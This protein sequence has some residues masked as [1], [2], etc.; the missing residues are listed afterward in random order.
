MYVHTYVNSF[1][2]RTL[3]N[4]FYLTDLLVSK[5]VRLDKCT[6]KKHLGFILLC[7]Y[8][9]RYPPFHPV[10]DDETVKDKLFEVSVIQRIKRD[11]LFCL[12]L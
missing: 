4:R 3:E 8:T 1:L 9:V 5:M 6:D 11:Y 10:I 2:I 7:H 12:V